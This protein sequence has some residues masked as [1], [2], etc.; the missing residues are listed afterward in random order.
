MM[1]FPHV[2]VQEKHLRLPS[3][4][5]HNRGAFGVMGM[6]NDSL[7]RSNVAS[8]IRV[9]G[10]GHRGQGHKRRIFSFSL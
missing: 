5:C 10:L 8:T 2:T 4:F 9:A 3:T 1:A 6:E 7:C